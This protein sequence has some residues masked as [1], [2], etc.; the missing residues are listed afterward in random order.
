MISVAF[1]N[2]ADADSKL[3]SHVLKAVLKHPKLSWTDSDK[4]IEI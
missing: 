1:S 3:Q 2:I 4:I